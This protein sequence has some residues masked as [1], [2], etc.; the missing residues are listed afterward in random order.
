[1]VLELSKVGAEDGLVPFFNF[2]EEL[3]T[4]RYACAGVGFPV[5]NGGA[6]K[7]DLGIDDKGCEW[8]TSFWR[9]ISSRTSVEKYN[10]DLPS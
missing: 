8:R 6:F 7:M 10:A 1:M 2:A 3:G 5:S 4:G 9:G